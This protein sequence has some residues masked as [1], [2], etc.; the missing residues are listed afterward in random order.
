MMRLLF[1]SLIA[2]S[3]ALKVRSLKFSKSSHMAINLYDNK[4]FDNKSNL[5]E[6]IKSIV[7]FTTA[8]SSFLPVDIAFA[9]GG[10]YGLLEG[11]TASMLHPLTMLAL[12]STSIYRYK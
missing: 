1:L 12:F 11:R 6:S 2:S 10:E 9:A 3:E 5:D 4:S 7:L 8:I